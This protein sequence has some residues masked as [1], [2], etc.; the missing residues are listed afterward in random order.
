MRKKYESCKKMIGRKYERLYIKNIFSKNKVTRATVV[1]DCGIEKE[2]IAN[3]VKIGQVKSCGCLKR[4]LTIS[5]NYKHGFC[6][7]KVY[8]AWKAIKERCYN[9]NCNGY[10][11]YGGRGIVVCKRWRDS[12]KNFFMDVGNPPK[13]EYSIDRIDNNGP[14]SPKNCRW[15]TQAQQVQNSRKAKI[16]MKDADYVRLLRKNGMQV[17]NIIK[18][19]GFNKGIIGHIVYRGGWSL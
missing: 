12:F 4:E 7:T 8:K 11:N 19:T 16:T 14:Y 15:A 3:L 10:K 5:K 2:V 18:T 6:G 1:C 17:K 13:K 9:I